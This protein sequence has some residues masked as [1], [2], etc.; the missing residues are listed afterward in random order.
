[1]RKVKLEVSRKPGKISIDNLAEAEA[2]IKESV[3]PFENINYKNNVQLAKHNK[4]L[5]VKLKTELDDAVKDA[6]RVYED[7]LE[8]MKFDLL[9]LESIINIPLADAEKT[10]SEFDLC[11]RKRTLH[12][13]RAAFHAAS[14]PLGDYAESV[15]ASPAFIEEKWLKNP[16]VQ[17][18]TKLA[19]E[20][21]V[22][23]IADD[24]ALICSASPSFAP[25]M[26]AKYFENLSLD[27]VEDFKTRILTAANGS[28]S[29]TPAEHGDK[30]EGRAHLTLRCSEEEF[31]RATEWLKLSG[32]RHSV[33]GCSFVSALNERKE[34]DFDSFVAIDIETTGTFGAASGD[35]PSEITE[36]GAV[37]VVNG[38]IVDRFSMLANPGRKITP[39]VVKL[40]HITDEM[41]KDKP[42]VSEV[43][44]EFARFAGDSIL[45][46]HGIGPNDLSYIC[47]TAE[48]I[49]IKLENEYFD[50]CELAA[51]LKDKYGW[52]KIKLEYL[53]AVLGIE[54][55][56]AHR[57]WCDAEANAKVYLIMKSLCGK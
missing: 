15:F 45:V 2:Y 25:V 12:G 3:K 27:E 26:L 42:P 39:A 8:K 16:S 40:T 23:K 53:S 54:Q 11:P 36:I 47:R 9:K 20:A 34:P 48:K 21:K 57:A 55:S 18:S 4:K 43:V 19:I 37:K 51:K 29:F 49:G 24:I 33:D 35:K 46:G 44:A 56:N 7:P 22:G 32:I 13:I 1:M 31:S 10:I 50:T 41:V 14:A 38:E 52:Q 17:M 5:L 6:I 28:F 30:V